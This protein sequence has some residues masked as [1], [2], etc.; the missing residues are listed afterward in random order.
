MGWANGNVGCHGGKYISQKVRVWVK[1]GAMN[2]LQIKRSTKKVTLKFKGKKYTSKTNK[3]GVAKFTIKSKVL[4]KLKVGKKVAY[5]ATYLKDT[6][7]KTAT[8]KK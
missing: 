6:V 5:Q 7:K 1:I 4:K 8:V 3:K 2:A